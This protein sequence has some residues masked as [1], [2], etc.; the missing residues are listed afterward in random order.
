MLYVVCYD[1]SDD[2]TRNQM[3]ERLLDF[4]VRIQE[5]ISRQERLRTLQ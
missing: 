2:S 3:S 5:V 1:I 4:G